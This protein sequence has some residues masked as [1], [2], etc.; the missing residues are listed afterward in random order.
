MTGSHP[1]RRTRTRGFTLVELMITLIVLLILLVATGAS[2][3]VF[4]PRAS[5]ADLHDATNELMELVEFARLRAEMTS[6]AVLMEL[7][8]GDAQTLELYDMSVNNCLGAPP[9]TPARSIPFSSRLEGPR[10]WEGPEVGRPRF[11]EVALT[12]VS[13]A[14]LLSRGNGLCFYPDGSVRLA[15]GLVVPA[16]PATNLA[17][18][19]ARLS[20]R[21]RVEQNAAIA[22]QHD[23]IIPYNGLAKV[24]YVVP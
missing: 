14:G 21:M 13:P 3:G 11:T 23:V 5:R 24:Q 17:A 10:G 12:G 19:E 8:D 7:V 4:S 9:P 18:G 1:E 15:N 20:L 22:I 2:L 6:Q 16:D